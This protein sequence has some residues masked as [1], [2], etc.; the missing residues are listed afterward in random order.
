MNRRKKIGTFLLV[1]SILLF[2]GSCSFLVYYLLL[3]PNHSKKVQDKYKDIYYS[4]EAI[5]DSEAESRIQTATDEEDNNIVTS[6][7]FDISLD[8][9]F[10]RGAKDKNGILKKFNRLLEYNPDVKGWIS[11]SDTCIDYPVLQNNSIDYYLDKDF[12]GNKDKN[13][14]L[15]IDEHSTINSDCKNIVIHGH[16]MFSTGMMFYQLPQYKNVEFYREHPII[17]FDTL[18]NESQWKIFAYMIVYG[19][20]QVND[21]FNYMQGYFDSTEEFNEFLYQIELRSPYYC[22]V[23]VNENDTLL[24]LSTCTGELNNGRGVVVARKVREDE[25]PDVN[26][27]LSYEKENVLYPTAWYSQYGG[28]APLV[29]DFAT[30]L[31]FN[32]INWY[33]GEVEPVSLEGT[34]VEDDNFTYQLTSPTTADLISCK[35]KKATQLKIPDTVSYLDRDINVTYALAK[36]F[37]GMKKLEKL[38]I[39]NEITTIPDRAYTECPNLKTVIIGKSVQ[40]IGFKAFF[41][42]DNLT[43]VIIKSETLEEIEPKAF[44]KILCTFKIKEDFNQEYKSLIEESGI[45]ENCKFKQN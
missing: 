12:D 30:A 40:S 17:T 41:G 22:P 21:G 20:P 8:Q 27:S 26:T 32:E 23:D 6:P 24:M 31:S 42:L 19:N 36:S 4:D 38:T 44:G 9:G 33:D 1:F 39:N 37:S 15:Y 14:S 13:G 16:N 43:N 45:D 18:Y 25:S 2:V 5:Y 7:S 3:Q 34:I 10:K 28:E 35:N 11:I 29:S